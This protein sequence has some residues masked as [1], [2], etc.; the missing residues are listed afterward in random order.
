MLKLRIITAL[1]LIPVVLGAIFLLPLPFF[2]LFAT[3]VYLLAGREWGRFIDTGKSNAVMVFLALV[4]VALMASVPIDQIWADGLHGWISMV[5]NA[6]AVWWLCAVPLVLGYPASAALWQSRPWL[7][8][9]FALLSLVPFFWSLLVL[10]SFHYEQDPYY[11]AWLLL[12]VMAL[13][14]AADT[15]AYFAGKT[16]GKHK[17]CPRVSPGKTMEGMV[18]GLI[19][20]CLLALIVTFAVELPV[21][22][23]NAVLLAS[24]VA[25]LASVLGDLVESMFKREAG[26]KDSGNILPGHGG[27][28]D[29]ID[30]LTAA[31]PIFIV[32]YQLAGQS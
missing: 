11:G 9:L 7:K 22:Q 3:A 4:L 24:V 17:L 18:G 28:M 20:A 30:S 25:V 29:R 2:A 32:V 31:L 21:A 10:R 8:A 1:C 15:G 12:F 6:G 19:A 13:V 16:L 14:W 5:L 26:L 23:R 27:M